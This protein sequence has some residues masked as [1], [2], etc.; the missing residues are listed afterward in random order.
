MCQQPAG[1]PSAAGE[2]AFTLLH[3]EWKNILA[4]LWNIIHLIIIQFII[5]LWWF[6]P[7][8]EF[9]NPSFRDKREALNNRRVR[10]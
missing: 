4:T 7:I 8:L 1:G 9:N 3:I 6:F 10:K 5:L 2:T